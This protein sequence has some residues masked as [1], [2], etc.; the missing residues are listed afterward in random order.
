MPSA[1]SLTIALA[2]RRT[3][4]LWKRNI[5][6]WA[7]SG[8]ALASFSHAS[9]DGVSHRF[10]LSVPAQLADPPEASM[11]IP[12][13]S[14]SATADRFSSAAFSLPG[15]LTISVL[16]R[17]PAAPLERQPRGVILMLS[18]RMASGMPRVSRSTTASVAS[19]VTSRGE[20]PVPPVDSTRDTPSSSAHFISSL[21]II[22]GSSGMTLV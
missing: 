7:A 1:F 20:K 15:R 13:H 2:V 12:W 16:P 9:S 21:F 6:H 8:A 19:G 11:S 10:A 3:V 5:P 18:A 17:M 14:A 4:P 22:S